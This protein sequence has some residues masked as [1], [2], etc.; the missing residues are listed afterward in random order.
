LSISFIRKIIR[1]TYYM[2]FDLFWT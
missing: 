2:L 1:A